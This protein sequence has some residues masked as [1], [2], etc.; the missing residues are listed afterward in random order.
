MKKIETY[1]N[2]CKIIRDKYIC[3]ETPLQYLTRSGFA[4]MNILKWFTRIS[5]IWYKHAKSVFN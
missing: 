3:T 5:K 2:I 4:L 1:V